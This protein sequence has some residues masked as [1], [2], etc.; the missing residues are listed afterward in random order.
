MKEGDTLTLFNGQG[1]EYLAKIAQIKASSVSV[2]IMEKLDIERESSLNIT[3]IQSLQSGEE[4]DLTIQKAVELGVSRIVPVAT[5]R[6]VL[7]LDGERAQRRLQRW[8]GIIVSAC[9]QCGRNRLPDIE[10]PEKLGSWLTRLSPPSLKAQRWILLPEGDALASGEA[11][12]SAASNSPTLTQ[13]E[14]LIGPEGGFAPEEVLLA[15]TKGFLPRCLGPRILRTETAGMAV[16]SAIQSLWG[17]FKGESH[18]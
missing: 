8:R 13:I 1:G 18:V 14:V 3:L 10:A 4:M 6:S 17:D 11:F 15:Q 5:Q 12:T 2:D 16:V 9:E 7:R